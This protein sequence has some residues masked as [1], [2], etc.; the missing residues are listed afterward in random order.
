MSEEKEVVLP[1]V[2]FETWNPLLLRDVLKDVNC[3]FDEATIEV[4]YDGLRI[5]QM[6]VAK[7]AMVDCFLLKEYFDTYYVEREGKFTVVIPDVLKAVF[8]GVKKTIL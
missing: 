2:S 4:S 6:D 7:V 1:V 5:K 3:F 8:T